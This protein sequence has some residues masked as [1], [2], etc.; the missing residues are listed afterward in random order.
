MAKAK[1]RRGLFLVQIVLV[2][3]LL[4]LVWLS[5]GQN[6]LKSVGQAGVPGRLGEL[7]LVSSVEGADALAQI[8]KLHGTEINLVEAYIGN[9]ARGDEQVTAWVGRAASS[10]LAAELI[11]RMVAGIS[12][13]DTGFSDLKRLSIA[14]GYH[15]HE[16]FQVEGPGGKHFFYV[17]KQSQDKIVWL[18]VEADDA[19]TIVEQ[20]LN[21]F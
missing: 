18:T 15:S 16:V 3:G 5:F 4:L 14:Q 2:G 20:A 17:S 9:Y 11:R 1:K 8:N 7:K 19:M 10:E 21:T 6:V 13:G 12:Q